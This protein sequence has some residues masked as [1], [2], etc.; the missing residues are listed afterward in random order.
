MQLG[1]PITTTNGG[2]KAVSKVILYPNKC[3]IPKLQIT[4]INTTDSDKSIV[5]TD[6]KKINKIKADKASD[7]KRNHFISLFI[8]SAINVFIKGRP[9][10]Y[11]SI[12]VPAV[13]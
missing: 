8:L 12:L 13:K 9:L 2:I 4:P 5:L 3:S 7:P 6:L 10:R 1:T 11:V